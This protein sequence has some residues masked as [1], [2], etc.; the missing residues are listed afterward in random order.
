MTVPDDIRSNGRQFEQIVCALF[1]RLGFVVREQERFPN[2]PHRR[3]D[4]IAHLDNTATVLEIKFYRAR[5]IS[6]A[7]L[8][9]GAHQAL[10]AKCAFNASRA[11][12][13]LSARV[14]SNTMARLES[15]TGVIT[16]GHDQLGFLLRDFP[17]LFDDYI[18][19]IRRASLFPE[20]VEDDFLPIAFPADLRESLSGRSKLPTRDTAHVVVPPSDGTRADS[21][22]PSSRY[23]PGE[24][25]RLCRELKAIKPPGKGASPKLRQQCATEFEAKC[26]ECLRFL[27]KENFSGDSGQYTTHKGLSRFD[28]IAR[29]HPVSAFWT[30]I[31][32]DFR[33][34]YVV[35]EFKHYSKQVGQGEILTTEKYLYRAALRSVAIIISPKGFHKN[36]AE[37]ANGA[38]REH[39]KLIMDVKVAQVCKMLHARDGDTSGESGADIELELLQTLD[40][41]LMGIER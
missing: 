38:L 4:A 36:A 34:R 40:K 22:S 8:Y 35:F 41:M 6:A 5:R 25:A 15:E 14:D 39:G 19:L 11:L 13:V 23:R 30:V 16:I 26:I 24:G 37:S 12:L 21:T 29:L 7:N 17:E 9:V 28:F 1:Q 33:S 20:P 10:E 31:Q 18:E 3:V 27:F 2:Q 32:E